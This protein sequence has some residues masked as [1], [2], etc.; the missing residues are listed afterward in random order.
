MGALTMSSAQSS[1]ARVLPATTSPTPARQTRQSPRLRLVQ[2]PDQAR[3]RVPFVLLCIGILA[4][5]LLGTL[6]LNTAMNNGSYEAQRLQREIAQQAERGS[7]LQAQIDALTSPQALA[8]RATALG[9]VQDTTPGILRL[10]D[11]T[12]VGG[13]VAAGASQ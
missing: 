2:A 9:M 1:A 12:I 11:G 10:A 3:S 8:Q 7:Q 5:A 13:G 6:L 4:V